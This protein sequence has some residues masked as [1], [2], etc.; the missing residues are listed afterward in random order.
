MLHYSYSYPDESV[1]QMIIPIGHELFL[2]MWPQIIDTE[3][4][5]RDLQPYKRSYDGCYFEDELKLATMKR[6]TYKNCL[7]E[8]RMDAAVK[9]CGCLPFTFPNKVVVIA[10]VN[11]NLL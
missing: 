1:P 8:R 4:A 3:E 11:G 10:S 6:Y 7:M 9:L 2:P 5:V